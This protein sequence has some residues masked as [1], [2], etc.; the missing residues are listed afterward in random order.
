MAAS[1]AKLSLEKWAQET[2]DSLDSL[3]HSNARLKMMTMITL[4]IQII[5]VGIRSPVG[6]RPGEL[7]K[8]ESV[9]RPDKGLLDVGA[10]SSR[11]AA[12]QVHGAR[13]GA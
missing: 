10:E 5:N 4:L 13:Q 2:L 1:K 9:T 11:A 6:S 3:Y 7:Q 8:K 12:K